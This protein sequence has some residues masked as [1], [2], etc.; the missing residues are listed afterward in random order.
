M[1]K[2]TTES[3]RANLSSIGGDSVTQ[4][5]DVFVDGFDDPLSEREL[6]R[7]VRPGALINVIVSVTI[8]PGGCSFG[9]CFKFARVL[10]VGQRADWQDQECPRCGEKPV[11]YEIEVE[12][13][14]EYESPDGD[15]L[16]EHG[17]DGI[18]TRGQE[19]I[20]FGY[21]SWGSKELRVSRSIRR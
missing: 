6:L 12:W 17:I 18:V 21:E 4:D 9:E 15:V 20:P 8:P 13:E 2:G 3:L 14:A 1:R 10:R 11:R 16:C 5:A 19:V 7:R